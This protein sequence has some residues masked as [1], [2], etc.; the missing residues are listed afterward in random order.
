MQLVDEIL[1]NSHQ[2]VDLADNAQQQG[3][4]DF[5]ERLRKLDLSI[6]EINQHARNAPLQFKLAAKLIESKHYLEK[7]DRNLNIAI[8]FAMWGEHNRLQ[9]RSEANPNGEDS[10]RVKL[11]QLSWAARGTSINWIVYAVDDGDPNNSGAIAAKIASKHPL[12]N[13][14]KIMQLSDAIQTNH[15]PLA[16]LKSVDESRKGGSIIYGCMQALSDGADVIIYTDAD[17]S[18]HLG[19]IG[20][21]LHPFVKEHYRVVLGNRKHTD[22]VL[23][24]QEGRW[25]IGIK[26]LRH[27]Q[28]MIGQ[29][30]FSLGIHDTQAAFKLY[31]RSV[32]E[33]IISDPTTYD[34]SFDTDWILA[35]IA[36]HEPFTEIPFAFI[37]SAAESASITQGPMTTWE[38]LIQGLKASVRKHNLPHNK[39]MARVI[40]DQI[41]SARDLEILINYLPEELIDAKD[42]DLGNP[43]IMSPS[44]V[45]KWIKKRKHEEGLE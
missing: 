22:S 24:K 27:I 12:G 19:Q 6:S 21:L 34:Y 39:E 42:A 45:A 4:Y 2:E 16:K 26:L 13:H 7:L 38:A 10:L 30:I 29:P 18:V 37:D 32:V 14:V 20:L 9:P 23:V 44:K 43:D 28:R 25:G 5:V 35:V 1:Q 11:Q 17:N 31:E 36:M 33:Q 15:G 41:R 8:V 3:L 40:D